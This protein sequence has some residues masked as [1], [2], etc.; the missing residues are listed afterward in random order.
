VLLI[1][2]SQIKYKINYI[3]NCSEKG[4]LNLQRNEPEVYNLC[5][6]ETCDHYKNRNL[7]SK[8]YQFNDLNEHINSNEKDA[9]NEYVQ[10]HEEFDDFP[11]YKHDYNAD[12][13]QTDNYNEIND[14]ISHDDNFNDDYEVNN[15]LYEPND[16]EK[17][18]NDVT[19]ETNSEV[20]NVEEKTDEVSPKKKDKS[21]KIKRR[22]EKIILSLEVQKAELEAKKKDTKYIDA[23]F[24]C[25]NCA[26]GFLFKDTYQ[27]H[28]MRHE[29]V[30]I[31]LIVYFYQTL[32]VIHQCQ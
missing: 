15:E 20:K 27:A 22:F 21:K 19:E 31:L 26:L 24:K 2:A 8:F 5:A 7:N 17:C 3:F 30:F 18:E 28:M 1:K 25:S 11:K 23:E 32:L 6:E 10:L 4:T 13:D 9:L 14:D 29:E 16:N 12:V